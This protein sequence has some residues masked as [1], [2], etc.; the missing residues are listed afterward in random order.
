[1]R[2][3]RSAIT[4]AFSK[5]VRKGGV[6]PALQLARE[7]SYLP[8]LGTDFTLQPISVR[9]GKWRLKWWTLVPTRLPADDGGQVALDFYKDTAQFLR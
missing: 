3:S 6:I 9:L 7:H 1:M 4:T 8:R 2:E 5:T